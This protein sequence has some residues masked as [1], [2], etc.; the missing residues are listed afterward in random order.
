MSDSFLSQEE[1]DALLEGVTGE[2][3]KLAKDETPEGGIRSYNLSSQER[4]VR[5]R[6]PTMEIVNERF[7]RNLRL[8]LFN[9]DIGVALPASASPGAEL[10]VWFAEPQAPGGCRAVA[11]ARLPAHDT[12]FAMTVNKSQGSEF[13]RVLLVLPQR[14]AGTEAGDAYRALTR[15]LLYTAVTRARQQVTLAASEAALRAAIGTPTQRD[16]GLRG[17]LLRLSR[18]APC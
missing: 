2:S 15:E 5:G 13:D 11:P 12:A 8:G 4:I 16:S 10:Q 17:R 6:M 7:S 1:V 14:S 18:K 9:G 3:Q